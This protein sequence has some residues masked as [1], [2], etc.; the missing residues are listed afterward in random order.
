MSSLVEAIATVKLIPQ[1][2]TRRYR[3]ITSRHVTGRTNLAQKQ[4]DSST[5]Y[6]HLH[7][8]MKKGALGAKMS[9]LVEAIATVK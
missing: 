8:K 2:V 9:S 4:K 3:T 1:H 7:I 6:T 5:Q